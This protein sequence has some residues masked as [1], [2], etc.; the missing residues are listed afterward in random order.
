MTSVVELG[1]LKEA[2]EKGDPVGG[3]AVSINLGLR[4]L[5]DTGPPNRQHTPDDKSSFKDFIKHIVSAP[6]LVTFNLVS[7]LWRLKLEIEAATD[8][9]SYVFPWHSR[10][11]ILIGTLLYLVS[12]ADTFFR[13]CYFG[14]LINDEIE[15]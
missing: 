15:T 8:K 12:L 11:N 13:N 4:D 2:E 5:S 14:S 1:R 10:L 3:S 7:H 6:I 9:H